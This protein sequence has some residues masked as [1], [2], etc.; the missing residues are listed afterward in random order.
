M[1]TCPIIRVKPWSKDQGDF[2]EVN[3]SDFDPAVHEVVAGEDEPVPPPE[4][5]PHDKPAPK[6]RKRKA[7]AKA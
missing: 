2:V 3:L 1:D 4:A 7:K 5:A 6:R